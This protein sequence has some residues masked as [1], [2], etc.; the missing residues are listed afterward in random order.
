LAGDIRKFGLFRLPP[1]SRRPRRT[2]RVAILA[3]V[4][5][6]SVSAPGLAVDR[7]D[8]T[9][10]QAPALLE[11]VVAVATRVSRPLRE[12]A[13]TVTVVTR[14][15]LDQSLTTSLDDVFRYTP[16]ID[17]TTTGTRFGTEGVIVRGIGGNRVAMELDGVPLSQQFAVGNFS[18]ATRDLVDVG[19]IERIEVLHGPASALYGSSAL[20]GVVSMTTPDPGALANSADG[21]GLFLS[22]GMQSS[23][24]S[25]HTVAAG[26]AGTGRLEG[27]GMIGVRSGHEQDAKAANT[28]DHRDFDNRSGLAKLA[29]EAPGGYLLHGLYY[30]H[31]SNVQTDMRSV[32][33]AGR[34]R[35]TT[36]LQGDDRY[37]LDLLAG[38]M[39]LS[40]SALIDGGVLRAWSETTDIRQD[41]VD[42]RAAAAR[43]VSIDR[44][45]DYQQDTVGVSSDLRRTVSIRG[46]DH[47]LAVGGEWTSSRMKESRNGI[48]AGLEDGGISSTVLGEAFPLRDFPVTNVGETG[49]YLHD[50][51]VLG[52]TRLIAGL[53]YDR[54]DLDPDP[55]AVYRE[56]NPAT[57]VVGI[58]DDEISPKLGLVYRFTPVLDGW[59]QYAHGFRAPSFE[60]ANIGLDIPMFNIRAIPNP[61]LKP[62]TSDGLEAGLRWRGSVAR[63]DASVFYTRYDDFIETKVRLG[64]DPES[65][66]LLF[67]SQNIE[68]ARIYGA[69]V[70]ADL[71]LDAWLRGASVR[72]GAYWARGDNRESDEPLNSVGPAQAVVALDWVAPEGRSE[73]TLVGTFTRRNSRLDETR[74]ELFEAPGY[75]VVDLFLSQRWG[76]HLLL[77]AG[78]ENLLDRTYWRWADVRGLGPDDPVVP[79]LSQPGRSVSMDLRWIF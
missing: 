22:Q 38:E 3:C 51:V 68:E 18:N 74:G 64:V 40:H 45:F 39:E 44:R 37:R 63:L 32:L 62:E 5:L 78:V 46:H 58:T 17:T 35:S 54:Y 12:V 75:A 9:D 52:R 19:L 73:V 69:E 59:A 31:D 14:D 61:D 42:E 2:D 1:G 16:G 34:F 79:L 49:V 10:D 4:G 77:R 70:A 29:F 71:S 41:T 48:E 30:H 26:T 36:A 66:R 60:D 72:A 53:R 24:N 23:D 11:P 47:Q 20:G 43:P 7:T 8:E 56:D 21:R 33:G 50:E 55:D 28:P 57:D 15:E 67:Q 76:R 13:G 65:G 6:V 27:L 25:L